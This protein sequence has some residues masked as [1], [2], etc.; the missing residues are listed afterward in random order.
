LVGKEAAAAHSGVEGEVCFDG[1]VGPE[2]VEVL[3]LFKGAEAGGPASGGDFF[4]LSGKGGA[5]DVGGGFDAALEKLAGLAG[6]G[7]A[8]EGE[9]FV[10]KNAGDF[11]QSV[12]VGASFD[13]GHDLLALIQLGGAEVVVEG[14]EVN[15]GPCSWRGIGHV[16]RINGN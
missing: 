16:G 3:H 5:K 4:A 1:G 2:L 15:L 9:R 11:E 12:A 14:G 8:E 13:D 7:D 10:V 6:I